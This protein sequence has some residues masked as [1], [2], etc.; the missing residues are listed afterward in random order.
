MLEKEKQKLIK[1]LKEIEQRIEDMKLDDT[2]K[3][4]ELKQK[5]SERER[6]KFRL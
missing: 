4:K 1:E 6:I 5:I 3:Y 2:P